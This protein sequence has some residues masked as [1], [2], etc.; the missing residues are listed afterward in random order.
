PRARDVVVRHRR[1]DFLS[2]GELHVVELVAG[3]ECL[4][5]G[6]YD[7]ALV[8]VEDR[9]GNGERRADLVREVAGYLELAVRVADTHRDVRQRLLPCEPERRL[10]RGALA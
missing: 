6:A 9:D 3:G 8:P 5:L 2:D 10:G 7:V 4:G 1:T